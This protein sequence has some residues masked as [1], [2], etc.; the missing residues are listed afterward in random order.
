MER[1]VKTVV[2]KIKY[3]QVKPV[4]HSTS[5]LRFQMDRNSTISKTF[6]VTV[7]DLAG[8]G[9]DFPADEGF[10]LH[11]VPLDETPDPEGKLIS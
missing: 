9:L 2:K 3:N 8:A 11:V 5:K 10:V 1:L 7:T 4:H 6:I